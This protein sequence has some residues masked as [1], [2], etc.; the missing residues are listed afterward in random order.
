MREHKDGYGVISCEKYNH[1]RMSLKSIIIK[2]FAR[3]I[4]KRVQ[5]MAGNAVTDQDRILKELIAKARNTLFGEKHDFGSIKNHVD[6]TNA[7]PIRDYEGM[8]PYVDKILD[9]QADILY[10]GTPKYLAKTSGTTSGIKYIPITQESIQSQINTS[11]AALLHYVTA[12]NAD[13][14]DGK[15]IFVSGSPELIHTHA[16]PTGRLSGIVNHEIPSWVKGNQLPSYKTNCIEDWE[17]KLDQIVRETLGQDMTL[18][19]GIPP[20]VQMYFER[21]LLAS[22]KKTIKE[23]FPNL[24]LFVHGGVNYEPYKST[25]DKMMGDGV[26]TLETYPASEGFIAFQNDI[27][28]NSL[29]LNTNAGIFYEFVEVDNIHNTS[30]DRLT[31]SQVELNKDYAILITSNA[32]LWS[33]NIGD[34]VRFTSLDPYKIRVSGRIKHFI[35]AFGEHVIAKE[36]EEAMTIISEEMNLKINDFTVAPQVKAEGN[37]LPYHEWFVEFDNTPE[38]LS[39]IELKLDDEISRQNIYYRDLIEGKILQTLIIRPIRKNGFRDYMKSIGKLGGQNKIP[40]LTNDRIIAD[41][42]IPFLITS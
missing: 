11:R 41:K 3:H 34:V 2:P 6:Y 35:S 18:I 40:R 39:V 16:I 27:D 9:G 26:D 37:K 1:I 25:I 30:P 22:G 4:S 28:D 12:H 33:Y 29:L 10:P 13:L 19:S 31:L 38:Q 17:E 32:G 5:K 23:I 42:L 24:Q 15:M 21:L 14:F 36:V 7:V 20:W 8:R